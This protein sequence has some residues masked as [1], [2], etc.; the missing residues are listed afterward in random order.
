MQETQNILQALSMLSEI[1]NM[2]FVLLLLLLPQTLSSNNLEDSPSA[3]C[4]IYIYT[5]TH[6]GI[7]DSP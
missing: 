6:S 5:H 4:T 3:H 2:K 1:C 7:T